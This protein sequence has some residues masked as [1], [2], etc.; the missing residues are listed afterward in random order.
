MLN[1]TVNGFPF[2]IMFYL[3]PSKMKLVQESL[4]NF[5]QHAFQM[6]TNWA[7]GH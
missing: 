5:E 2:T 4:I 3:K 6:A 1:A 7:Y